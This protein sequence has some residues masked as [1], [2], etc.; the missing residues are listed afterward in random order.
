MWAE[1]KILHFTYDILSVALVLA[2]LGTG[3]E[4]G[5]RYSLSLLSFNMGLCFNCPGSSIRGSALL[6]LC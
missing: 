2:L 6:C 1:D 5:L 3:M 4:E